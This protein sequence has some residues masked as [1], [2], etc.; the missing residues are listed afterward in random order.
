MAK[1]N[2]KL[3]VTS[4]VEDV[5]TDI[6]KAAAYLASASV[7]DPI[8]LAM[9]AFGEVDLEKHCTFQTNKVDGGFHVEVAAV[10][11]LQ[12]IWDMVP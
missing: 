1:M 10:P 2:F 12:R 6:E 3:C 5:L 8:A 9:A 4:N 11:E 7:D